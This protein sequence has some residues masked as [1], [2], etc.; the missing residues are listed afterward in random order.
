M[1][2]V[3]ANKITMSRY[4]MQNDY[5]RKGLGGYNMCGIAGIITNTGRKR[6]TNN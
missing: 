5:Y 1:N 2:R 3:V 4:I 6:R